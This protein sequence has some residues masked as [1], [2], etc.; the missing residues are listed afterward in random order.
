MLYN[1][2]NH[3]NQFLYCQIDKIIINQFRKLEHPYY[4][5]DLIRYLYENVKDADFY[6]VSSFISQLNWSPQQ[7]QKDKILTCKTHN[8]FTNNFY[9]E[10]NFSHGQDL[11]KFSLQFEE[12]FTRFLWSNVFYQKFIMPKNIFMQ[13][14]QFLNNSLNLVK[15]EEFKFQLS[16]ILSSYFIYKN[17]DKLKLINVCLLQQ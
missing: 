15:N 4:Q 3:T 16:S 1:P 11:L 2:C 12:D 8:Q 6:G 17:E 9:F 7:L 5:L 13:Y 14:V 10:Q